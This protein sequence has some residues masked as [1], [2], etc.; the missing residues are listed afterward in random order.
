MFSKLANFGDT[1]NYRRNVSRSKF[2][3]A[4]LYLQL[5]TLNF[6]NQ[7]QIKTVCSAQAHCKITVHLWLYSRFWQITLIYFKILFIKNVHR[8]T[9]TNGINCFPQIKLSCACTKKRREGPDNLKFCENI[10]SFEKKIFFFGF[11]KAAQPPF[12]RYK[13]V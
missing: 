4:K 7:T 3:I 10:I 11:L 8:C 5:R 13:N 6:L 1:R 12:S 9:E 2:M